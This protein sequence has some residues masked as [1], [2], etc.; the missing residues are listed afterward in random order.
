MAGMMRKAM[1]KPTVG[2]KPARMAS[3]KPTVGRKPARRAMPKPAS[4]GK[5]Y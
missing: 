1:Q 4:K 5:R 3:Q 2:R